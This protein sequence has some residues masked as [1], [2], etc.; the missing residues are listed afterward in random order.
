MKFER[1]FF[2]S[3][4]SLLASTLSARAE[5]PVAVSADGKI[6][7]T[8]GKIPGTECSQPIVVIWDATTGK[9]LKRLGE[10]VTEQFSAALSPD[11]KLLAISGQ[12]TRK[13]TN[14]AEIKQ[15]VKESEFNKSLSSSFG[16]D[17][18]ES[19]ARNLI[20]VDVPTLV[21]YETDTGK[22]LTKIDV[23][24]MITNIV[25]I[26]PDGTILAGG[27][28]DKNIRLWEIATGK[29]LHTLTGLEAEPVS[30]SFSA[31]GKR[32]AARSCGYFDVVAKV[33]DLTTNQPVRT[34]KT[35]DSSARLKYSYNTSLSPNGRVL[36]A[37]NDGGDVG[38]VDL[39]DMVTGKPIRTIDGANAFALS[40]DSTMVA[41]ADD[42]GRVKIYDV[43]T[44]QLKKSLTGHSDL[45]STDVSWIRFAADD[46]LVTGNSNLVT[47]IWDLSTGKELTTLSAPFSRI[48]DVAFD[49]TGNTLAVDN[50][51]GEIRLINPSTGSEKAVIRTPEEVR[52]IALTPDGKTMAARGN[53]VIRL[54]DIATGKNISTLSYS[55]GL[56]L[57]EFNRD[58]SK[59]FAAGYKSKVAQVWDTKTGSKVFTLGNPAAANVKDIPNSPCHL[60]NIISISFSPDNKFIATTSADQTVRIWTA[61]TGK[62]VRAF[63][64]HKE[65]VNSARYSPDGK[66]IASADAKGCLKIWDPNSGSVLKTLQSP[67]NEICD[68]LI[69][70]DGKNIIT[71]TMFITDN[72]PNFVRVW[73]KDSGEVTQSFELK[74]DPANKLALSPDGK[75][76]SAD[77][78]DGVIRLW[79]LSNGELKVYQQ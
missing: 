33:W 10:T 72:K 57:F 77:S 32:L 14:E 56:Y 61:D 59:A 12:E 63:T 46:K 28:N 70:P 30:L 43:A 22:V 69:T 29:L 25:A 78:I 67:D 9:E 49:S 45:A 54:Y 68:L 23:G 53:S 76:L 20:K 38:V 73:D 11:G 24:S 5:V 26:S 52:G 75:T 31:D 44:G 71:S 16:K 35:G 48:K 55:D 21:V 19:L 18:T 17:F 6:I 41:T 47:K 27:C 1:I 34:I 2:I 42:K 7:A 79:N 62:F 3:A 64:G 58:G 40:P 74:L 39:F 65:Q 4:L 36:A 37:R 15:M 50:D 8:P 66:W 60:M 13:R 51:R